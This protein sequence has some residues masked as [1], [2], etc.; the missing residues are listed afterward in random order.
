M[1]LDESQK[2]Q[3]FNHQSYVILDKALYGGT[4]YRGGTHE[5]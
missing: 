2:A 5:S 1:T 4:I 3:V